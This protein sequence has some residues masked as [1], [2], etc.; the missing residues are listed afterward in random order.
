MKTNKNQQSSN[1][2]GFGGWKQIKDLA[3]AQDAG[4]FLG[5]QLLVGLHWPA[6]FVKN[7]GYSLH[8]QTPED[9]RR[10]SFFFFYVWN[11]LENIIMEVETVNLS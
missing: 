5:S 3:K 11:N 10:R 2:R 9:A 8:L 1:K 7:Q 6:V 4:S